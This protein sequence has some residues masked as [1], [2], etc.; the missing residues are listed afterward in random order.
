MKDTEGNYECQ[1]CGDGVAKLVF[2]EDPY[3]KVL[4]PVYECGLCKL[5]YVD[6]IAVSI[7]KVVMNLRYKIA[8]L[9]KENKALQETCTELQTNP[10]NI[11]EGT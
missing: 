11:R 8:D 9:E 7:S 5:V 1:V 6:H 2:Q 3:A 10:R 4:V